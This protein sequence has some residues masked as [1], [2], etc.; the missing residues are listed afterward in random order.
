MLQAFLSNH[1]SIW[2]GDSYFIDNFSF[3]VVVGIILGA[4]LVLYYSLKF[5]VVKIANK[6]MKRT[7]F[8]VL[9]ILAK[10]RGLN[11]LAHL[12]T[13]IFIWSSVNFN[14]KDLDIYY[15][16][17]LVDK[18]ALL[19]IFIILVLMV[20]KIIWTLNT[21]YDKEFLFAKEYPIYS[22]LKVLIL[23]VWI[24]SGILI[25]S[26]FSNT[27]PWALLTGVGAVSAV[28]L[29]VFKDT[30]LGIVASIQATASNIVRIGDSITVGSSVEGKVLDISV[31]TVKIEN[32]DLTIT[33][34]PT[35]ML[36]SEIVKNSRYLSELGVKR[37]KRTI[38]I[39]INTI[40]ICDSE[41]LARL[42]KFT[43]VNNYLPENA[44]SNDF[45]NLALYRTYLENYLQGHD[46]INHD[47]ICMVR[48]L[49]SG[50]SGLPLEIYAF[51]N[52]V[53]NPQY[54]RIQAEIFEHCFA[55]LPIFGLSVLQKS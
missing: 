3:V 31:N 21:Y 24:I 52:Q 6:L 29:L 39:D 5:G 30:L 49:N 18:L 50:P 55:A 35:Y 4:A 1:L 53:S 34:L 13:G 23:F 48:H 46:F 10:N 17:K 27:S 9:H 38:L 26:F 54:E 43:L 37:I 22:Y 44:D 45:V 51:V 42:K 28:F 2:F 47:Y 15:I 33:N 25:I 40:K 12:I 41:L 19:Y 20:T 36:T 8:K 16:F 32:S 14:N 11:L 7:D